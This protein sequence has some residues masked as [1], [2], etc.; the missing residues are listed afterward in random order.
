MR[1]FGL[2]ISPNIRTPRGNRKELTT[3]ERAAII[4][5]R[6]AGVPCH[7]LAKNFNCN[8]STITCTVQ[9]FK[10]RKILK[11]NPQ[12]GR[13]EKLNRQQKRYMIQL[14]KRQPRIAW[15]ALVGSSSVQV[16]KNTFRR[17]LGTH[18]RRKWRAKKRIQLTKDHAALRLAHARNLKRKEQE[19]FEV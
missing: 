7:E 15:K 18:Y 8:V 6:R 13:P 19:L 14:V 12:T 2:E 3:E 5:A 10:Q 9:H 16:C 17:V 11:F 1:A 4:A